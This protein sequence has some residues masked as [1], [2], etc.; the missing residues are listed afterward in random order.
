MVAGLLSGC[1]LLGFRL[2][3]LLRPSL[4][5]EHPRKDRRQRIHG[6][7]RSYTENVL[8]QR[9]YVAVDTIWRAISSVHDIMHLVSGKQGGDDQVLRNATVGARVRRPNHHSQPRLRRLRAHQRQSRAEE[10]RSSN[11][12]RSQRCTSA[13]DHY[14]HFIFFFFFL[15]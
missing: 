15:S 2:S 14:R 13:A 5:Q 8:V 1:Q 7:P 4:P 12:P 3:D 10:R 11:Q 6:W 9:T